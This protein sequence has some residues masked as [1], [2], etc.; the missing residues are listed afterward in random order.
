MS[1]VRNRGANGIPNSVLVCGFA[2]N[3]VLLAWLGELP[4]C[5]H[6]RLAVVGLKSFVQAN[7]IS[8]RL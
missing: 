3:N 4:N 6:N 1:M 5:P 8:E 7:C 2:A